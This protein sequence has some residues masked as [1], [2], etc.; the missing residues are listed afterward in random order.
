MLIQ[1]VAMGKKI[2]DDVL[3]KWFRQNVDRSIKNFDDAAAER[4]CVYYILNAMN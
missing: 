2:I 1:Y 3:V 4:L